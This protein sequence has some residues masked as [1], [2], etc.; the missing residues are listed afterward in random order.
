MGRNAVRRTFAVD[1]LE[2]GIDPAVVEARTTE[3]VSVA[4]VCLAAT[5]CGPKPKEE[6]DLIQR[7]VE[8][9]RQW[10]EVQV[11]AECGSGPTLAFDDVEGCIDECATPDGN[12][13]AGWGYQADTKKDACVPEWNAHRACVAALSCG[14]RQLYFSDAYGRSLKRTVPAG[15]SSIP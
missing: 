1:L 2:P 7:R 13:S 15:P 12:L 5:A 8:P 6:K 3:R 9:C 11:D 10:C 14:D 4:L